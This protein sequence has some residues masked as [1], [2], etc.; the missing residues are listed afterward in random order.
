MKHLI[1]SIN[2]KS[3]KNPQNQE[4]YPFEDN[5]TMQKSLKIKLSVQYNYIMDS[6]SYFL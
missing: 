4:I 2:R 1:Y 6:S 5:E 3:E